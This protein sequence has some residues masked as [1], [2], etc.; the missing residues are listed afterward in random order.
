MVGGVADPDETRDDNLGDLGDYRKVKA[1]RWM[2]TKPETEQTSSRKGL[3][4]EAGKHRWVCAGRHAM[5]KS[6]GL[7]DKRAIE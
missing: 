1:T 3:A 6:L 5:M 2:G 7:G 4:R